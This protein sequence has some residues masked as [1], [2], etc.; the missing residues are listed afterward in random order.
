MITYSYK[1]NVVT[2]GVKIGTAT[3]RLHLISCMLTRI[4]Q[5]QHQSW[6]VKPTCNW[7]NFELQM[8]RFLHI[9]LKGE[10]F[11][12]SHNPLWC[13]MVYRRI[14]TAAFLWSLQYV[15]TLTWRG[16]TI[17]STLITEWSLFVKPCVLFNRWGFVPSFIEI[18][19]VLL[20]KKFNVFSLFY[21]HLP[22]EKCVPL[23]PRQT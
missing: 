22:L 6:D 4:I 18:D 10:M 16:K 7:H 21:N 9:V 17:I 1:W 12:T 13:S 8:H 3:L 2:V 5:D 23:Q 19:W 15:I 14:M 20:E 11:I